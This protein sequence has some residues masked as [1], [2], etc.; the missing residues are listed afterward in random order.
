M[1]AEAQT[2]VLI[3]GMWLTPKGWDAWIDHYQSRGYR[4]IAP[5][6]PGVQDPEETRR[7]PS[8]LE[9]L[10]LTTI[11]DHYDRIIRQLDRPP[12]I[13]GHSFGGLTTQLL[14]NR[15][16][17]AAGVAI[18]TAPPKGILL[19]PPSTLRAGFPALKNPFDRNGLCPISRK[20]FHWRFMNTLSLQESDRIYDEQ[21][22]P[23][24]NRPFFDALGSSAAVDSGMAQ[25]PPLL[26]VAGGEDHISPI[27]LNRK[28]LK[29]QGKAPSATELKEYPGRPHYMAGLDGWDEIA[30]YALNWA[31]EHQQAPAASAP[32]PSSAPSP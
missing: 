2:V 16:L 28:I 24:T 19:L 20:Q 25:R 13:V 18:G 30:D 17:G 8:A 21:Y 11:V 23:G 5:G 27:S 15:G 1:S 4:P 29:L 14:L 6:W 32:L 12:I 3:H 31:L 22:I 7:N 26:L 9:G 10:T